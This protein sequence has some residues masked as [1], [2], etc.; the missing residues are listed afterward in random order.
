MC[1]GGTKRWNL[2]LRNAT[3]A[4]IHT[5]PLWFYTRRRRRDYEE[6]STPC[7]PWVMAPQTDQC[8]AM[9]T[10]K[11]V[12]SHQ[13]CSRSF[14]LFV[15][16]VRRA[17]PSYTGDH[18]NCG[19]EQTVITSSEMSPPISAQWNGFGANS[20]NSNKRCRNKHIRPNTRRPRDGRWANSRQNTLLWK[21][22]LKATLSLW[23]ANTGAVW[24]TCSLNNW[25]CLG[26]RT[27]DRWKHS[28]WAS[29]LLRPL[30]RRRRRR[31]PRHTPCSLTLQPQSL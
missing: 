26:H 9:G 23:G 3:K 29:R 8:I 13:L 11:S 31:H 16:A 24:D 12:H 1:Y 19:M 17:V 15:P 6:S 30:L 25:L 27:C 18:S 20:P 4:L 2:K 22:H 28:C 7:W 5:Y 14:D 21:I 10:L